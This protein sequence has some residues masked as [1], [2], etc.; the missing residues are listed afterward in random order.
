MAD[1]PYRRRKSSAICLPSSKAIIA[2]IVIM[3]T[4]HA[5]F[6]GSFTIA[7]FLRQVFCA[8][9]RGPLAPERIVPQWA[10]TPF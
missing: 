6:S 8:I 5:S 4:P 9:A 3:G 10:P 7:S 2:G 1:D